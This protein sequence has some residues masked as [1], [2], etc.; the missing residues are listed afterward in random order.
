MEQ[1]NVSNEV[2]KVFGINEKD[3]KYNL[4]ECPLCYEKFKENRVVFDCFHETCFNCFFKLSNTN[5]ELKCFMCRSPIKKVKVL[6]K[7]LC[8]FMFEILMRKEIHLDPDEFRPYNSIYLFK[9]QLH[10]FLVSCFILFFLYI[11]IS[12]FFH[13]LGM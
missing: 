9:E 4:Q 11:K 10:Y 13:S 12:N 8:N 5:S 3:I 1:T 7:N 6:N 2:F